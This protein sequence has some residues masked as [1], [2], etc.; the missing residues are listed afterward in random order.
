MWTTPAPQVVND[1][2]D[3]EG[4]VIKRM[5]KRAL[6]PSCSPIQLQDHLK[7]KGSFAIK[8]SLPREHTYVRE[9]RRATAQSHFPISSQHTLRADAFIPTPSA[10]PIFLDFPS[11]AFAYLER[12]GH[13]SWLFFFVTT[14]HSP[15]PLPQINKF[16][17]SSQKKPS[18]EHARL[19]SL[20]RCYRAHQSSPFH[21]A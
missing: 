4:H 2:H 10:P 3:V 21:Y 11:H 16:F 17:L 19:L 8:T 14:V 12:N 7:R 9:P 1:S 6:L 13:P 20:S 18:L 15:P 5:L